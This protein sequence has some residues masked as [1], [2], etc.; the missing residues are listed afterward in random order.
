MICGNTCSQAPWQHAE[1]GPYQLTADGE[2]EERE[3]AWDVNSN[4]VFVDSPI[5]VGF[6][7]SDDPR[8]RVF[9]ESVTAADLLDFLQDFLDGAQGLGSK[10]R[11]SSVREPC[12]HDRRKA[13]FRQSR[14]C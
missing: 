4:I 12:S 7:Y 13:L 14:P 5:G 1:N 11:P 8:D 3:I 2:V 10:H 6:S 9:N